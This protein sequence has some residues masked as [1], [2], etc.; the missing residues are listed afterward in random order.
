VSDNC[1]PVTEYAGVIAEAV[2]VY[3]EDLSA[4]VKDIASA[5]AGVIEI[6]AELVSE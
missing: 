1:K 5:L 6:S 4:A 3:I 2:P